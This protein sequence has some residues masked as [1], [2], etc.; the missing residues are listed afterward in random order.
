MTY[1]QSD[2]QTL[3]T[4]ARGPRHGDKK[5]PRSTPTTPLRASRSG[6]LNVGET[7]GPHTNGNIRDRIF[8]WQNLSADAIAPD[9][10]GISSDC[11]NEHRTGTGS[12][13]S[14]RKRAQTVTPRSPSR[15]PATPVDLD[16]EVR[17][18]NTPKKRLVSDEHW[19]KEK[20]GHNPSRP[21]NASP[22]KPQVPNT[23]YEYG[24]HQRPG[25]AK[26]D[27]LVRKKVFTEKIETKVEFTPNGV[28]RWQEKVSPEKSQEKS[29]EP[30]SQVTPKHK[31]SNEDQGRPRAKSYSNPAFVKPVP[32]EPVSPIKKV[33]PKPIPT[34][35]IMEHK[36]TLQYL[37]GASPPKRPEPDPNLHSSPPKE[38]RNPFAAFEYIVG[39]PV[40]NELMKTKQSMDNQDELPTLQDPN[41]SN[42]DSPTPP[43]SNPRIEAWLGDTPEK[44]D[45]RSHKAPMDTKHEAT[46]STSQAGRSPIRP[47]RE[48][49]EELRRERRKHRRKESQPEL[50]KES[51]GKDYF[52]TPHEESSCHS[53]SS[54]TKSVDESPSTPG[55]KRRGAKHSRHSPRKKPSIDDSPPAPQSVWSE[56][57]SVYPDDSASVVVPPDYSKRESAPVNDFKGRLAKLSRPEPSSPE[58]QPDVPQRPTPP[59]SVEKENPLAMQLARPG[60]QRNVT[61]D[62]DLL[63]VLSRPDGQGAPLKSACSVRSRKS[64]NS[65]GNTDQILDELKHEEAKYTRELRTLID[66]VIPVLLTTVM[67]K[68]KGNVAAGLFGSRGGS[69]KATTPIVNMGIALERLRSIHRRMSTSNVE[70]LFTWGDQAERVYVDYIKAWRMGFQHVV[71]NLAPADGTSKTSDDGLQKDQDGFV[72]GD[73][74]E[75]VDVAYLLK[76]PLVR[77]KNL[78]K[79][80]KAISQVVSTKDATLR[81][82]KYQA[83]VEQAK[84]K[85]N[86]EKARLEDEAAAS[87]DST[88]ARDPQTLAP[89]PGVRIDPT[90]YVRARD[91]FDLNFHH[92]SG[93]ILDCRVELIFRDQEA[94]KSKSGDVLICELD[95]KT[96]WL[97]L[98]PIQL[99]QISA[100]IDS[101]HGSLVVMIRGWGNDGHA[102]QEILTLHPDED[103]AISEWM[104]MLGSDP[105]PPLVQKYNQFLRQNE[106]ITETKSGLTVP[107]HTSQRPV[108]PSEVE[109]PLG[110]QASVVSRRIDLQPVAP[111]HTRST[112]ASRVGSAKSSHSSPMLSVVSGPSDTRP[113][114]STPTRYHG[115]PQSASASKIEEQPV[116]KSLNDALRMA[117]LETSLPNRPRP[118]PRSDYSAVNVLRNLGNSPEHH[119]R[120]KHRGPR[121]L[122]RP[123]ARRPSPPLSTTSSGRAFSVWMPSSEPNLEDGGD[124]PFINDM[125]P[126]KPPLHKRDTS[127]PTYKS[128]VPDFAKGKHNRSASEQ[129]TSN[130]DPNWEPVMSGG[131]D[132]LPM[133]KSSH[134]SQQDDRSTTAHQ[135]S[136]S[137]PTTPVSSS[138]GRNRTSSAQTGPVQ[139]PGSQTP[140]LS[141]PASAKSSHSPSSKSPTASGLSHQRNRRSSSPLKHEYDP[142]TSVES[143][144]AN[145]LDDS[146]DSDDESLTSQS[147]VEDDAVPSL[148]NFSTVHRRSKPPA[149]LFEP[150]NAATLAPSN[151]ASQA[152]YR[153][154][155]VTD[156]RDNKQV[157][158]I[159]A[160]SETGA[161]QQVI[162]D[163]CAIVVS[164]GLIEAFDMTAYH[165][166]LSKSPN[167]KLPPTSM[168][169]SS[170]SNPSRP[171]NL[172]PLLALEL[173][174]LV[175]LRR[176]T[177][178]D[179]SIRSPPT[180]AS[181]LRSKVPSNQLMFRSRTNN[182]CDAL[183]ASINHARI[184]NPTYIALQNARP[185]GHKKSNWAA[186]MDSRDSE[187]GGRPSWWKLGRSGTRGRSSYRAGSSRRTPSVA[188]NTDAT[189]SSAPESLGGALNSALK[190][191][192][193]PGSKAFNVAKSTITGPGDRWSQ[194]SAT[195]S[196]SS[197]ANPSGSSTPPAG[198]GM[199]AGATPADL[200]AGIDPSQGT[201]LGIRNLKIRLYE[202]IAAGN[203]WRDRGSARLTILQPPR[204]PGAPPP[205]APDGRLVQSKRVVVLGKTKGEVLLD[206]TLG[207]N[208]FERVGRVGIAINVWEMLD[209]V[210]KRG[211]VMG[212]RV[213]TYMVQCRGE[214]EAGFM[215][216]LVG[217][218]VRW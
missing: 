121:D 135:H 2:N 14:R 24:I 92:S 48:Q 35:A 107:N 26:F 160:W 118:G 1:L 112:S 192:T 77:V 137:M 149:T 100:R 156:T 197:G 105:V 203:H 129:R 74:G 168:N 161:W 7:S 125:P 166:A 159:F 78:S 90:R 202:R 80:F 114:P 70:A 174:P 71:V 10:V 183:Y 16:S 185:E 89:L 138:T 43:L 50:E 153:G 196:S 179:I 72:I 4:S 132:G 36:N 176:G 198:T 99:D 31:K 32:R 15:S 130:K 55:L 115:N 200:N 9:D 175:P 164:P 76:R 85:Q 83:V 147:S 211:S 212:S 204:P 91:T 140:H 37:A 33:T 5:R 94:S 173:T 23:S 111:Q 169:P 186:I 39:K 213:R 84:Q 69:A 22:S 62:E 101:D 60:L 177:A 28:V 64:R 42:D 68:D 106:P 38:P 86:E 171:A 40:A 154:V 53:Q 47:R 25:D 18:S 109:V 165:S 103:E 29:N 61:T 59:I 172:T 122:P 143:L 108:T 54:P 128:S 110:E 51:S 133:G 56:D 201:P 155:P 162:P 206:V 30:T 199:G 57:V 12:S 151:S 158:T 139:I 187:A 126:M 184:H 195:F 157:A 146:G 98:P 44:F 63:S 11:E 66:G 218:A 167:P 117:G 13:S 21:G 88:R 193:T 124:D 97:L 67:S 215:F 150:K 145:I 217:R 142:G 104:G 46:S 3:M 136:K 144:V 87:I 20:S 170:P 65:N 95:N 182:E 208:A 45:K 81:A 141:P 127:V 123:P 181:Q 116:P 148:P 163:E 188:G 134:Q 19:M 178:I 8:Q 216:G 58:I 49:L 180:P 131:R 6:P 210:E 73:Q 189:E 93:Q 113:L 207:E 191:L 79:T 194:S 17:A 119:D 27:G 102:W 52:S 96:K 209:G 82:D 205:L 152:A 41:K 120:S 214:A 75:R 190:R 34:K